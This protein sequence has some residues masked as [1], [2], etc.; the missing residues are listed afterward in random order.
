MPIQWHSYD[1]YQS[2]GKYYGYG[3]GNPLGPTQGVGFV[4]ELIAR[5]TGESVKD[6]TSTNQTLNSS[7]STFPVGGKNVLF[8][9]FSH[10]NDM[11]GIFSAL[12]LYNTTDPLSK[13]T[14]K[15]ITETRGYSAS[16]TVPFASRAYIEKLSCTGEEE[17]L[18]RVVV[19]DRVLPL[20]MCGGDGLGACK[21]SA[22]VESLSFAQQGGHWAQCFT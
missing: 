2:L 3:S 21:L 11:T 14:I 4:N 7:P 19:N 16:W 20:E 6:S 18:V 1:Y 12:G 5:L 10:D 13:T 9:D 17:E 22:F 8:A 15:T